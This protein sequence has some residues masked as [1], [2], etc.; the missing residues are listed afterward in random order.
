VF[1]TKTV[2]IVGAGASCELGLPSGAQLKDDIAKLLNITFPDGYHQKTGD[3]DICECFRALA[4]EQNMQ[5]I[6]EFLKKSCHIRDSLP[7]ALSI[8]NFLDAHKDDQLIEQCGKLAIAKAIVNAEQ[9]S[10]LRRMFSKDRK[11]NFSALEGTWLLKF[12]QMLTENV[13]KEE[14]G[15]IFANISIITFNYDR[16]IEQFLPFALSQYY[17]LDEIAAQQACQRLTIIHPYGQVGWLPWQKDQ[18]Q[19]PFGADR[20]DLIKVSSMLRTFAE[21]MADPIQ[22]VQIETLMHNAESV[23]FLGFAFHPMNM[24]ILKLPVEGLARK[25]FATTYGLSKADCDVVEIQ[26]L[27]GLWKFDPTHVHIYNGEPPERQ[28]LDAL[29]LNAMKS[30]EFLAAYFRSITT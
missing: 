25:A 3:P 19:V 5:S 18:D 12:F 4:R 22:R 11:A 30:G 27:E 24:D 7:L 26:I 16:C 15:D 2:F 13:R 29:E 1:K 23:V 17:G 28:I 20:F 6:N 10:I 14:I 9:I 21:G 8:D